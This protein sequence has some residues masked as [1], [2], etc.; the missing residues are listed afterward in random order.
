MQVRGDVRRAAGAENEEVVAVGNVAE[1]VANEAAPRR[2]AE[3]TV[4]E[5]VNRPT[6]EESA[7][8]H[9][10][11]LLG[12]DGA[13]VED[14]PGSPAVEDDETF[15]PVVVTADEV[16]EADRVSPSSSRCHTTESEPR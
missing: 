1:N 10:E 5:K 4:V 11:D 12:G 16:G 2:T 13:Y 8:I 3:R 15:A 9:A 14:F 7:A 6:L